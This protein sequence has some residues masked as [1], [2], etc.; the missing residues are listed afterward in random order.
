MALKA[1]L[2]SKADVDALPEAMRSLYK[3]ENGKWVLDV[4]GVA[5]SPAEVLELKTKLGEFRENNRTMHGELEKLKPL[6]DKF[7]DVDP[8]EYRNLKA[9]IEAMRAKGVT[10]PEDIASL[11]DAAVAKK[12]KSLEDKVEAEKAIRLE[13][14]KKVEDAMFRDL[15]TAEATKAGVA[16]NSMRFVIHDAEASFMLKD[17]ALVPREGVKHPTEPH[18]DLTPT[19]WLTNLAKTNG[20]LF[21]SSNGGGARP[22]QGGGGKPGVKKLIN[23]SATEMGQYVSEIA[24]GE[25]VVVRT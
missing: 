11:V 2:A 15:V 8:D 22:P 13:A 9:E 21:E 25:V 20:N 3:E 17:G 1:V 7:K 19:D 18:K 14:Q 10:R 23:P 12:T 5:A 6:L 16:Q 24:K 4:E